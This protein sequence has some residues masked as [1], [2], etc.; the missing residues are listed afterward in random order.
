MDRVLGKLRHGVQQ[1]TQATYLGVD[2]LNVDEEGSELQVLA[3][4]VLQ[5]H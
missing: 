3:V 5:W 4:A 2:D 1:A